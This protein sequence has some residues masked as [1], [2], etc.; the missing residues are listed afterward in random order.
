[1]RTGERT[2]GRSWRAA[3]RSAKLPGP[4]CC[5][6]LT[7]V[8]TPHAGCAAD[9]LPP[10][11]PP[12]FH[13]HLTGD[14]LDDLVYVCLVAGSGEVLNCTHGDLLHGPKLPYLPSCLGHRLVGI[15]NTACDLIAVLVDFKDD[16]EQFE[17]EFLALLSAL[18]FVHRCNPI[19]A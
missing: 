12:G 14:D 10:R 6:W 2:W 1:M 16:G 17:T 5:W 7:P 13:G 4:W 3:K 9:T 8:R 11:V 15:S 18:E 19:I